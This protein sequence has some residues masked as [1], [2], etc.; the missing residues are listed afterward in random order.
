MSVYVMFVDGVVCK[1]KL[2][3]RNCYS[4]DLVVEIFGCV[5]GKVILVIIDF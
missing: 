1:F 5:N 4:C 3:L 2:F